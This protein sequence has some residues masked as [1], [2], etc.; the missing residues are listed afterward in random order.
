MVVAV[1]AVAVVA[2]VVVAVA[3]P[4]AVVAVV[5]VAVAAAVVAFVAY[6]LNN[7]YIFGKIQ[8][9]QVAQ[10]RNRFG[11]Q[12]LSRIRWIASFIMKSARII[13]RSVTLCKGLN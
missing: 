7:L 13:T 3:A 10:G 1:A 11:L 4:A 8:S 9:A 12:S 2:V 6:H 5:V